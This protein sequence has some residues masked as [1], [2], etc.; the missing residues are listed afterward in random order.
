MLIDRWDKNIRLPFSPKLYI[1]LNAFK[2]LNELFRGILLPVLKFIVWNN[3]IQ[4]SHSFIK[5]K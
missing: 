1:Q 4:I 3:F 2:I 5:G